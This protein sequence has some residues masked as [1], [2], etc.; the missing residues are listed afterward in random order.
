M[1]GSLVMKGQLLWLFLCL[2]FLSAQEKCRAQ[3]TQALEAPWHLKAGFLEDSIELGRPVG[4]YIA[5]RYPVSQIIRFPDSTANYAPF[6]WVSL[7]YFPS[8][9][10]EGWVYDSAIYRLS[11]FDTAH[12][13]YLQLQVIDRLPLG[14]LLKY[15]TPQDSIYLKGLLPQ[16]ANK[17]EAALRSTTAYQELHP[18]FNYPLY[19]WIAGIGLL[20]LALTAFF[21]Y[22]PLLQRLRQRRLRIKHQRFRSTY[23][24]L[25]AQLLASYDNNKLES[26]LKLWKTYLEGLEG[27]P[28]CKLS[29]TEL[30]A[31]PQN[32]DLSEALHATDRCL[33]GINKQSVQ[34]TKTLMRHLGLLGSE[35]D[36]RCQVRLQEITKKAN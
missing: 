2:F 31:Y 17:E 36:K 11:S 22:R 20:V 32:K 15:N 23:D 34:V 6:E 7:H 26:T 27:F 12:L 14:E 8:Q 33:Y 16:P 5:A 13:Q 19:L 10:H 21:F 25:C 24:A 3:E 4:F 28:Y 9:L 30:C 18:L 29:S 1:D 35:A